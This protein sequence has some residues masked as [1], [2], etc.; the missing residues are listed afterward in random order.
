MREEGLGDY[1][2]KRSG[3]G[4]GRAAAWV[5]SSGRGDPKSGKMSVSVHPQGNECKP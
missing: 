3:P 1:V 2:G 5:F 4:A